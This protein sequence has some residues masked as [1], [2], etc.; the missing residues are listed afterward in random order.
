VEGGCICGAV[1]YRLTAPPLAVYACHC[2]DCQRFASGPYAIGIIVNRTGFAVAGEVTRTDRVA[3]SGRT[4]RQFACTPCKCRIWHESD[5]VAS[6]VIVRAGTL[7]DPSWATPVAHIWTRSKLPWVE[8]GDA[9]QFDAAI[10]DRQV[11]D[12]AWMKLLAGAEIKPA[13]KRR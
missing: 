4:V 12:D 10:P 9:I 6:T 1:R 2:R 5:K 13:R 3:E 8:L 11:L 7:D